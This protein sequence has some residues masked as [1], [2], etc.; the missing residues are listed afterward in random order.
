[1]F[2][3]IMRHRPLLTIF[4]FI[5]F[6]YI[7]THYITGFSCKYNH[8]WQNGACVTSSLVRKKHPKI[9]IAQKTGRNT[10]INGKQLHIKVCCHSI[11][12]PQRN[13]KEKCGIKSIEIDLCPF[14]GAYPILW[15]HHILKFSLHVL[16]FFLKMCGNY[17][18]YSWI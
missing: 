2:V 10:A 13:Y 6:P 4:C 7:S 16:P 15:R 3:F 14:C 1:M 8:F 17:Q 12:Y 9:N 11:T 5:Y 18:F